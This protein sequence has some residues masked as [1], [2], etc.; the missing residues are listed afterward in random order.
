LPWRAIRSALVAAGS[1][2]EVAGAWLRLR[3]RCLVVDGCPGAAEICSL[4]R[5]KTG[6]LS[7]TVSERRRTVEVELRCTLSDVGLYRGC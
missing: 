1:M 7:N 2:V 4:A 5:D 3:Q 6:S